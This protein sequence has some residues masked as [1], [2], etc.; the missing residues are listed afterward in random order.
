LASR[1]SAWRSPRRRP[2]PLAPGPITCGGLCLAIL[3]PEEFEKALRKA[4]DFI[5][6]RPG[7]APLIVLNSDRSRLLAMPRARSE[8]IHRVGRQ[9]QE[10]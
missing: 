2:A 5:D 3:P 6:A 1:F 10:P 8:A 4:R 7:Q 9:T